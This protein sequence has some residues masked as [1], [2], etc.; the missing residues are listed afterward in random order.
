ML[1]AIGQRAQSTAQRYDYTDF[2][3]LVH[4]VPEKW[5]IALLGGRG[6]AKTEFMAQHIAVK[7][8]RYGRDARTLIIRQGPYKALNDLVMTLR[9]LFDTFWGVGAHSYGAQ[10]HV[11]TLPTGAY[12]ELGV[13]PDGEM[14]R[15]Y[16][17]KAYQGRSFSDIIFDE[18]QQYS[19]GRNLDLLASN[20]RSPIPNRIMLGA[21]PGG[22]G[23]QWIAGRYISNRKP[24]KPFVV[25]REIAVQGKPVKV[26]STWIQCPSTY[27]DN[28]HNPED[29]LSTLAAACGDD[30][31][32]LA[33]WVS[34]DWRISRGA[35]FALALDNP[36]ISISWGRPE[37]W[38]DWQPLGWSFWLA[39]DH[40]TASPSPCYVMASSPGGIGPDGR[41]YP[42]DSILVL[43]EWVAHRPGDLGRAFG[44]DVSM[45]APRI[46]ELAERWRIPA[47]GVADDACFGDQGSTS[48]TIADEYAR[49]GVVFRPAHK[50]S[51]SGRFLRMRR[52]LRLAGRGEDP[53]LFVSERCAYFWATVPF[54]VIDEKDREVPKKCST[55]HGADAVSYGM[56]GADSMAGVLRNI[57]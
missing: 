39:F 9:R 41:F 36:K 23:H 16:Y 26:S 13:L 42:A 4:L 55:D 22:L 48:G 30:A 3:R 51:R 52:M 18:A 2:Q 15:L 24:W 56:S 20:L 10:S 33:A 21:N 1:D 35:Y 47:F 29:Y 7:S 44:W 49:F 11:W 46:I 8:E 40:G 14:G 31:E 32:L 43:D 45:I 57:R 38:G 6:G 17:E 34:G 12:L 5:W 19:T 25:E 54:L 50:G 37:D 28:P 53:G 27:R